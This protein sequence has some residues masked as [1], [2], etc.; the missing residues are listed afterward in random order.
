M[1]GISSSRSNIGC[2]S[3]TVV[4]PADGAYDVGRATPG[5]PV[6]RA[7]PLVNSGEF[8]GLGSAGRASTPIGAAL[9]LKGLG[10]KR[11]Q[12]RLRDW[13]ISRQRYWGCPIPIIHC[14]ACGAVPVPD[15]QLPVVLPED[16]VPDGSGNPLA[17]YAAFLDCTCPK[18]GGA[19]RRETDT[20]DTFVDS[21][22]Y[23]LRY[24]CPDAQQAH[25][26]CAR[27]LL[28]AGGS[29]HRRHRAR[30]P[31]SAVLALLDAGDARSAAGEV[32]RAVHAPVHPGHG[33][34]PRLLRTSPPA[35]ASATSI[36]PRSIRGAVRQVRR[37]S[38]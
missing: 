7:R 30:D 15:E 35:D 16:L 23:F 28:A 27:G 20:M 24:A 31:A 1:S 21:S 38:R 14:D 2:R 32:R 17:K 26:R 13:G 18:C 9:E 3:V 5:K 34:E 10:R 12:W 33:A 19:A 37:S 22:W 11:V 8:A 36:P 6:R 29:V 4:R 25:G